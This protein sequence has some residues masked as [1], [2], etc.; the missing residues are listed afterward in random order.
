M[1]FQAITFSSDYIYL[2][3]A[4]DR[5]GV[6]SNREPTDKIS[7]TTPCKVEC[8]PSGCREVSQQLSIRPEKR[9]RAIKSPNWDLMGDEGAESV[10]RKP[11]MEMEGGRLDLEGGFAQLGQVEID[12]MVRGRADR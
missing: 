5:D 7:K 4:P 8:L 9:M 10:A 1:P 3:R 6:E 12:G 11:A 2:W